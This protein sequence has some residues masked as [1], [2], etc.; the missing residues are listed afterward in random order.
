MTKQETLDVERAVHRRYERAARMKEQ[1]L[2]CPAE[3]D[4]RYLE[5]LPQEIL[6]K[7]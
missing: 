1:S 7:D 4:P 2:C 5:A 6:E 3:Y